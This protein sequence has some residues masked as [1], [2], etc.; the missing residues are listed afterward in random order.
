MVNQRWKSLRRTAARLLFILAVSYTLC[1]LSLIRLESQ[2]DTY[3]TMHA[4]PHKLGRGEGDIAKGYLKTTDGTYRNSPTLEKIDS[5]KH[6][7]FKTV[8]LRRLKENVNDGVEST[9]EKERS[10]SSPDVSTH[11]SNAKSFPAHP[12][13]P[14]SEQGR[15]NDR[16]QDSQKSQHVYIG[17]GHLSPKDASPASIDMA[18]NSW[19]HSRASQ[20][21]VDFIS[22]GRDFFVY[23]AYLDDRFLPNIYVRLLM[24]RPVKEML[25]P[26]SDAEYLRSNQQQPQTDE[27]SSTIWCYFPLVLDHRRSDYNYTTL[28][29]MNRKKATTVKVRALPYEMCENHSK[30]FGG[31]IYSCLVPVDSPT[32]PSKVAISHAEPGGE[33]DSVTLTDLPVSLLTSDLRTVA[34]SA[35]GESKG[36]KQKK[37]MQEF[38]KIEDNFKRNAVSHEQKQLVLKTKSNFTNKPLL[39][40]TNYTNLPSENINIFPSF[41]TKVESRMPA[42]KV[43][44]RS[45]QK[46]IGVCVPPLYGQVSLH[47]LINFIEMSNIMGADQVFLYSHDIPENILTYLGNYTGSK[48]GILTV[49]RWDLPIV[50]KLF[51][52][53]RAS[54]SASPPEA[55]AA[56]TNQIVW[57]RGQLLAVQHCLYSNMADFEWLLFMDID[58]MLVPRQARTW[59]EL[60][61]QTLSAASRGTADPQKI[62]GVS[63][64][65]AFFQ[66]DFRNH[67]TNSI[68]YFQYLHRTLQTSSLRSKMLVRPR[69]VFE[70]GIHHL[71]KPVLDTETEND[72]NSFVFNA[73]PSLALVHHYRKCVSDPET[74]LTDTHSRK[75]EVRGSVWTSS[76][77]KPLRSGSDDSVD[78]GDFDQGGKLN[79][80]CNVLIRDET[81]LK[82]ETALTLVSRNV[83]KSAV[84]FFIDES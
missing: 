37:E 66:Q 40:L 36:P 77:W 15:E 76:G 79:F 2:Q 54:S 32:F 13:A 27:V 4:I 47:K 10:V 45:F 19:N 71:S 7:A 53:T 64:Q 61:Q 51:Q 62:S 18:I 20:T 56:F 33:K 41:H 68:D 23:G 5:N 78:R 75:E 50:P 43:K 34:K 29:K 3:H 58:E 16:D 65:S 49:V 6:G 42:N 9:T 80:E 44:Q 1:L 72:E 69:K 28:H 11:Y 22:I 30:N 26:N 35:V 57:N 12:G 52:D 55:Q 31:W 38:K 39:H 81:M 21:V 60:I 48:P 70:L 25:N 82:Y 74:E 63:F 17:N 84:Q 59:P 14:P 46:H 73:S 67:V 8:L 24:L 83:T